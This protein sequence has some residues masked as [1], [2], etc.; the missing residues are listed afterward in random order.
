MGRLDRNDTTALQKTVVKQRKLALCERPYPTMPQTPFSEQFLS[1]RTLK[2]KR[3]GPT[4]GTGT[5]RPKK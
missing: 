1:T 4:R 3:S 2:L 5:E